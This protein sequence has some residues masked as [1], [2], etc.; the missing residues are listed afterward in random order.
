MHKLHGHTQQK[1]HTTHQPSPFALHT[2]K[3]TPTSNNHPCWT[4]VMMAN[5]GDLTIADVK[6]ALTKSLNAVPPGHSIHV[7][8]PAPSSAACWTKFGQVVDSSGAVVCAE[9]AHGK[10]AMMVACH[11][12]MAIFCYK[13]NSGTSSLV[14]HVCKLS[15]AAVAGQPRI[16]LLLRPQAMPSPHHIRHCTRMAAEMCA[17]PYCCMWWLPQDASVCP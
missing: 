9:V 13:S 1:P 2:S 7:F 3:N 14:N 8:Q 11:G 4:T 15:A 12:C 5:L 6:V 16:D 10:P 17:I